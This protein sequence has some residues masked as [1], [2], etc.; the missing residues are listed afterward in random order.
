MAVAGFLLLLAATKPSEKSYTLS[1]EPSAF[2]MAFPLETAVPEESESWDFPV[3]DQLENAEGELLSPAFPP[4]D[5][6]LRSP[7]PS[8]DN[9]PLDED[10]FYSPFH[11]ST[12]PSYHTEIV[13]DSLTNTYNSKT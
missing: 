1:S 13:F 7:I 8:Y 2:P 9:N 3:L 5:T 4:P 6:G 11:L 12:P 10:Q